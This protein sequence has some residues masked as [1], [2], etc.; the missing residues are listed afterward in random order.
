MTVITATTTITMKRWLLWYLVVVTGSH[1]ADHCNNYSHYEEMAVVVVVFAT[2]S[3][4][5]EAFQNFPP[6]EASAV[7]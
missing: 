5:A 6:F 7:S 1:D 2:L 4:P 3:P